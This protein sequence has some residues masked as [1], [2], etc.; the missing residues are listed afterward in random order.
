MK[1][2]VL[3]VVA[4]LSLLASPAYADYWGSWRYSQSGG[5]LALGDQ[6]DGTFLH[7]GPTS[8]YC[9]FRGESYY[10]MKATLDNQG[11]R[12]INWWINRK[13]DDGYVRVCLKNRFEDI[14]CST[15]QDLGWRRY[16]E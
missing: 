2:F 15:Y 16:R 11:D 5:Y 12:K 4:V 7:L 8:R 10:S 9:V 3:F 1:K 13:C 6:E 14:T